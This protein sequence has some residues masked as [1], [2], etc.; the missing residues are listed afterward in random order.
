MTDAACGRIRSLAESKKS[1]S[2][3]VEQSVKFLRKQDLGL[4]PA[5]YK[6]HSEGF[7][8]GV[9]WVPCRRF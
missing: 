5:L 2:A 8:G 1:A 3:R 9:P 6:Y 4:L 7:S